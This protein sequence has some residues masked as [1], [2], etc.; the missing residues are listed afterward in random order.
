MVANDTGL[1]NDDTR[2]VVD[3][4]IFANLGTWVDVDTRLGVG[5]LSD[6][7]WNDGHVKL[8][9]L[10]GNTVVRHRVDYRVAEDDLAI[11][12]GCRVVVEHSL[13]V[14]IEQTL[15]FRQGVD[16]L[17][18]Q[19]FGLSI[20]LCFGASGLAILTEL[21]SVGYLLDEQPV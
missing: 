13:H 3:G 21:E 15:D 2:T 14:G 17:Q 4:E 8:M 11:V 10:V 6:D 20:N 5:L 19:T 12:A 16:E 9:Q 1:A 7:T 18:G